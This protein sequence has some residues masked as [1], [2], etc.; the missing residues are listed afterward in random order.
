[1]DLKRKVIVSWALKVNKGNNKP[2]LM[3]TFCLLF[4]GHCSISFFSQ[5][6]LGDQWTF[7]YPHMKKKIRILE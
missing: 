4:R 7:F 5:V 3:S 2:K 1:M 6:F